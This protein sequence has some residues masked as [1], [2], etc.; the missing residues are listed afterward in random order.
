MIPLILLAL[1]ADASPEPEP[2][3]SFDAVVLVNKVEAKFE[4]RTEKGKTVLVLRGAAG[5]GKARLALRKGTAPKT[6]VIRFLGLRMMRNVQV[7]VGD[8]N[9]SGRLRD[10]TVY[11]DAKGTRL[12]K[13]DGAAITLTIRA[14]KEDIEAV[15]VTSDAAKSWDFAWVSE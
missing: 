2:P 4:T 13:P 6:V 10:G 3:C 15:I 8:L 14:T 7:R 1:A 12:A 9:A 5:F 11:F